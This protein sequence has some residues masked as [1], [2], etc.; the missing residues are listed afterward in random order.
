VSKTIANRVKRVSPDIINNDQSGF[1]KGRSIAENILLI[2]GIINFAAENAKPGLLLFIDFEKVFDALEWNFIEKFLRHFNFGP[3][4]II[5][6]RL[7]YTGD[8]TSAIRKT[9]GSHHLSN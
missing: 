2:D 1:L 9:D 7:F 6:F 4:L 8:I 5:W 3:S